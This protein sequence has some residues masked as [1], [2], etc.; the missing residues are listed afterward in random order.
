M[1]APRTADHSTIAMPN[2]RQEDAPGS[3]PLVRTSFIAAHR[4]FLAFASIIPGF[5]SPSCRI[6]SCLDAESI[7]SAPLHFADEEEQAQEAHPGEHEQFVSLSTGPL[8]V[9][10]HA[11]GLTCDLR[12][13]L[14]GT[15]RPRAGRRWSTR[16][17]PAVHAPL[18][19]PLTTPSITCWLNGV[20]A[21]VD[22]ALIAEGHDDVL[23]AAVQVE[24]VH[25]HHVARV[26]R[27]FALGEALQGPRAP[28]DRNQKKAADARC[29]GSRSR[30][31]SPAGGVVEVGVHE[32]GTAP[33]RL[34]H[35]WYFSMSNCAAS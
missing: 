21:P 9:A 6:R 28:H 35:S 24:L 2:C 12:N 11:S 13:P 34:D 4:L 16:S 15:C 25:E 33:G 5:A 7:S 18:P 1:S 22:R 14:N 32:R 17:R 3:A 8:E 10:Q 26:R 30:T 29:R 20:D 19:V 31:E 27:A 23:V